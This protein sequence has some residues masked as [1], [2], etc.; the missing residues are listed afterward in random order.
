MTILGFCVFIS[1]TNL[2]LQCYFGHQ[3]T[4]L[5]LSY[6]DILYESNWIEFPDSLKKQLIVMIANAQ[7]PFYYNAFGVANL[8][9]ETFIKVNSFF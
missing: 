2:F 6:A 7:R 8:N 1:I 4:F 3:S 9:L 5:R